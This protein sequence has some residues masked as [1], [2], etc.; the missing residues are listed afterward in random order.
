MKV[1]EEKP[2]SI[3]VLGLPEVSF[4]GRRLRFGRKKVLALL[5]YLA[6]EGRKRSRREL[7]ELFWPNSDERRARKDLRSALTRLRKVLGEDGACD[8]E[9]SEGVRLLAIDGDLLGVE[10]RAVELDLQTL[11]A[12]VS[13]AWSETSATLP[14]G[15]SVDD[16]VGL[17]DLIAHLEGALG[18][19]R[20]E[21]MEGFSLED[22]PEFEL[23]LEAE[24]TRWRRP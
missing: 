9:S 13:L 24:R 22:A 8:G 23:W 20:G 16:A 17:R 4:E 19:Y 3:R 6:T 1:S 2:L 10:P 12:A 21:F 11:E 7:A 15:R 18:L 14:R 5:C